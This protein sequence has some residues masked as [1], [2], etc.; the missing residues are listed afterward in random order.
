MCIAVTSRS[1]EVSDDRATYRENREV[2]DMV[3]KRE[4]MRKEEGW[5]GERKGG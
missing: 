1:V 5:E 2:K 3:K 4:R